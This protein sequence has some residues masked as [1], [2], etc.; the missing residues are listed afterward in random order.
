MQSELQQEATRPK[1]IRGE[2]ERVHHQQAWKKSRSCVC[3]P[4]N[5]KLGDQKQNDAP[6]N[7]DY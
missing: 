3:F 1:S 7:V 5:A 6:G 2:E 4:K